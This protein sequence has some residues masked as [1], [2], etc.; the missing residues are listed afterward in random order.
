MLDAVEYLQV[1]GDRYH[2]AREDQVVIA[3]L[4]ERLLRDLNEAVEGLAVSR[5]EL[6]A[7]AT[8][9]MVF[10]RDHIAFE[11]AR[12]VGVAASVLTADDWAS[13]AQAVPSAFDPLFGAKPEQRY[14]ELARQLAL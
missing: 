12:I 1:Y 6:E 14:R 2:H 3:R 9:Y 4:G 5:D 10:Y 8:T 13:I 7:L 11:E